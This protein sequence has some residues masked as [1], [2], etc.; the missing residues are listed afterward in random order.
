MGTPLKVAGARE[1]M[2]ACR[3]GSLPAGHKQ[4]RAGNQGVTGESP[5]L[6]PSWQ[7]CLA[8]VAQA[9]ETR[10]QLVAL[11]SLWL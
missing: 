2:E 1:V 3:V 11:Q 4:G 8:I 6:R 5:T 10:P 7:P 9:L